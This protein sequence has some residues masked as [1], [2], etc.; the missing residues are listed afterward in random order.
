MN[1]DKT[2]LALFEEKEIRRKWKDND[3]YFSV[4][5]VVAALTDSTN[6]NDYWYRIKKR[7]KDE[8]KIELST[9]CRQL[10]LTSKD[11]KNYLTDCATTKGILRIIQSIPSKKAEPFKLWLAQVGSERIEEINDPEI[12]VKRARDYYKLKGYNEQWINQRMFGIEARNKLTD[13]WQDRGLTESKDY[14]ILTNQIYK[15]TFDYSAKELKELKQVT[16]QSKANLRD[17]MNPLELNIT[18]L[19]ELTSQELHQKNNSFGKDELLKDVKTAGKIASNTRV[20][21]EKELG[22]TIVTKINNKTIVQK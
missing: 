11:G 14:A 20:Q 2:K 9:I 6:P 4:V 13:E 18:S 3:W 5:D 16:P 8:E 1:I 10:K 22:H 15:S 7:A 19:A 21:V 12:A 17:R